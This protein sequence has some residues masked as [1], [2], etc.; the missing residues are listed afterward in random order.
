MS[1]ARGGKRPAGRLRQ[2]QVISTFGP[3]ALVD[4]PN[5][6]VLVAGLDHWS[7]AGQVEVHELRLVAKLEQALSIP[8]LRLRTP[9]IDGSELSAPPTGITVWRFPEWFISDV[10]ESSTTVRKRLLA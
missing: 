7:S 2:S 5:H 4:L 8:G 3:G 1:P 6:S 10:V 9:P